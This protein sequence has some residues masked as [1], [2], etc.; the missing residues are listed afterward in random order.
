MNAPLKSFDPYN[1]NPLVHRDRRLGLADAAWVRSFACDDMRVL[2]VCRGPVRKEAIEVF[3]EMGMTDVG[4]LLS[5]R[6]SIVFAR[7]LSPEVRIMDPHHVHPVPDYSGATKD[8]R[9]ERIR[10]IIEIC[11]THGYDYVFAGYGF[12]AEDAHFVRSLEEAGLRFIGPGSYPQS[13]A[14]AKDE[15]KRTAI[16]NQVSVTPGINDATV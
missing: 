12:M 14:G 9:E 3:R 13:A 5:E 11:R 15:A 8:E 10:Q 6:D 1:N 2:I 7:A 4:M 16:A